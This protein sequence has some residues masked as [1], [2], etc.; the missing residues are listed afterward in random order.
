MT[1]PCAHTV[2]TLT[3]Q[4]Q[5]AA[6]TPLLPVS[7]FCYCYFQLLDGSIYCNTFITILL[8]IVNPDV[9]QAEKWQESYGR[10][11]N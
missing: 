1:K 8:S 5:D 4:Q 3:S 6:T 11:G 2:P 10:V 9:L 7:G